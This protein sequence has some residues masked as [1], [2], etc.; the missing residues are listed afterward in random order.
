LIVLLFILSGWLSS[1]IADNACA[2]S[3]N[4]HRLSLRNVYVQ[5]GVRVF[6]NVDGDHKIP[7]QDD[8]N[9]NNVP[10][11]IEDIAL[12]AALSRGIFNANGFPDPLLSPR[13]SASD[14][15]DVNL[16]DFSIYRPAAINNRGFA[17]SGQ[18]KSTA[19][20]LRG[21][22]CSLEI[23]LNTAAPNFLL[24]VKDFL[25]P[26]EVFHLYQYAYAEF[27]QPWLH[28][29]LAK[30]AERATQNRTLFDSA[31]DRVPLPDHRSA[32]L[33]TVIKNP[34]PYATQ[35][36]WVSLLS[37]TNFPNDACQ[38]LPD[39]RQL[40]FTDG[41]PVIRSAGWHGCITVQKLYATLQQRAL[42]I[43]IT[44]GRKPFGWSESQRR[45]S[46]CDREIIEALGKIIEQ[47]KSSDEAAKL[48]A[49]LA[50]LSSSQNERNRAPPSDC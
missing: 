36:F 29:G 45:N 2:V 50:D 17:F 18:Y 47:G 30:W 3:N 48:F 4:P 46:A 16:V 20:A 5:G 37:S 22:K 19:S 28:E 27:K 15:I 49:I 34:N 31:N 42:H 13:F 6:Y 21:P 11:L 9:H 26:H 33:Q 10:D 39:W 35:R 23:V 24:H 8:R 14:Y 41:S 12:H 1:A 32:F 43:S 38:I 40:K 44:K 7:N 25:I